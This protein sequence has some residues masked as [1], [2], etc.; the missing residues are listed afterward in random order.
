MYVLKL[1]LN[2]FTTGIEALVSEN[3]FLYVCVKEVCCLLTQL[4]FDTVHQPIIVE[5][6]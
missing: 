2:I 6:L 4:C 5:A 1:L 3:T